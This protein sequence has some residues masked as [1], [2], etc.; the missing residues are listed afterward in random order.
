MNKKTEKKKLTP[1]T[2][3]RIAFV[4]FAIICAILGLVFG[5]INESISGSIYT[6]NSSRSKRE[7]IW[8]E[9]YKELYNE[10]YD[11]TETPTIESIN[12]YYNGLILYKYEYK[13]STLPESKVLVIEFCN[14]SESEVFI[15]G[16][17]IQDKFNN[18]ITAQTFAKTEIKAHEPT[19]FEVGVDIDFD[20]SRNC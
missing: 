20:I 3:V 2:A 19:T 15:E 8:T 10:Y 1:I 17:I 16:F 11:Q 5:S 9:K 4:A 12:K 13:T 18:I 7:E 14:I 6:I